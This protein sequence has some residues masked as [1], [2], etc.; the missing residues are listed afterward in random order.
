MRTLPRIR[1]SLVGTVALFAVA[2]LPTAAAETSTSPLSTI[3]HI[4]PVDGTVLRDFAP[5]E[6]RWQAGHRG[7]DLSA[8][9]GQEVRAS[10]AGVVHFSGSIAGMTSVSI[11]HADGIRTTY[12]PITT[13]LRKGDHVAAGDVIGHLSPNPKHPEPGLHWGALRGQDYLNPLDLL[14]RRPIVL[15]PVQ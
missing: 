4:R 6:K 14:Q 13:E 8:R 5:P 2:V 9:P 12:Q 3:R 11:M 1:R 10:S 7:V 15:K